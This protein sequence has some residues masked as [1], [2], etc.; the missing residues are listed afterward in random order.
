MR[1]KE[2]HQ[3]SDEFALVD[4]RRPERPLPANL[5]TEVKYSLRGGGPAG[6]VRHHLRHTPY[7]LAGTAVG[8]GAAAIIS[9][10]SLVPE[11]GM[12]A[13]GCTLTAGAVAASV[14]RERRREITEEA[15]LA[16]ERVAGP[17]TQFDCR[18]WTGFFVGAPRKIVLRYHPGAIMK[19]LTWPSPA[20][21]VAKHL[22][23]AP[24]RIGKHD[25]RRGR[26]VLKRTAPTPEETKLLPTFPRENRLMADIFGNDA[27][28]KEITDDDGTTLQALQIDHTVG[29]KVS[30][31]AWRGKVEDAVTAM[32]PGKW[33]ARWDIEGD[34][35][36]F[37][38][39]PTMPKI[40]LRPAPVTDP[41]DPEFWLIPLGRDEDGRKLYWD[42]RSSMPH[43]LV[44]GKTGKGKTNVLRGV[45]QELAVRGFKVWCGDP[46]RVELLGLRNC[47]NVQMV[48]TSVEDMVA[49]ILLAWEEMEARYK[50]WEAG[51]ATSMDD[52]ERLFLV[53][54]EYSE[55]ST[56]VSQW[57]ARV[58]G[59]KSPSVCPVFEKVDSLVRLARKAGI[60]VVLGMQRCDAK[61]FQGGEG[62][63][64]FDARMSLG[65]LST[66][67]SSMLWDST[68]GTA[69]PRVRGRALAS[70]SEDDIRE[71]QSYYLPESDNEALPDTGEEDQPDSAEIRAAFVPD[72]TSHLA[73][74][75]FIPEAELDEKGR[76]LIWEAIADAELVE[77]ADDEEPDEPGS[78]D[79]EEDHEAATDDA[80]PQEDDD[81]D[82]DG[83]VKIA[84]TKLVAGDLIE[85]D[86]H[87]WVVV[88]SS[89]PDELSDDTCAISWRSAEEDTDDSGLE[90]IGSGETITVR[91]HKVYEE[92][93]N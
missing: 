61:F 80:D 29:L 83:P 46:K 66:D 35:V 24:Y 67:G 43:F 59:Q 55:F 52:F 65:A 12:G 84:V 33:R 25:E 76:P 3:P 40:V 6:L 71:V 73:L 74:R 69:L 32:L 15:R 87:G 57:W 47:P 21:E 58:R 81:A 36:T 51:E 38:R 2:L 7:G 75:V 13:L 31:P 18:Q 37:E 56:R 79:A 22:F 77:R 85:H 62:R 93:R 86:E 8:I 42:L 4:T 30:Q 1:S 63:D 9:G 14:C 41:K 45:I 70:A 48:T 20:A 16:M 72:E 27:K 68:I 11:V 50:R 5:E 92:E 53:L 64:N 19:D 44:V 60:H 78:D 17:V 34:H 10:P 90:L 39:R 82:Y 49:M 88:E 23:G 91:H 28:V 26:L 89:E 54:D